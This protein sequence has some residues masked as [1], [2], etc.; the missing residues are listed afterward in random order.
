MAYQTA[1]KGYELK[2]MLTMISLV[3]ILFF[4]LAG[5]SDSMEKGDL[6]VYVEDGAIPIRLNGSSAVADSDSVRI[7]G[8]TIMITGDETY[9]ISGTLDDGMI[10]VNAK[11]S[12]TPHIVLSGACINSETSAAL[13]IL[14]ADKVVVTLAEGTQNILSNGG[15]F[16]AIDDSKID[17]AIFS[18]QD[19]T[20]NGSGS[21]NVTSPVGH[22][23]VCKKDLV[24]TGGVYTV[25][26]ASHGM[27]V[28]DSGISMKGIKA[29][30][31]ILIS[32]GDISIDS[33]DDAVHSDASVTINGG[34]LE[35]ASGDDAVHAEDTLIVTAGTICVLESYEG[36]EAKNIVV[37]GGDITI[38]AEDDGLNAAASNDASGTKSGKDGRAGQGEGSFDGESIEISGG[39]ISVT[40][41]GDGLDSNG[42]IAVLGG[43]L[44]ITNPTTDDTSVLDADSDAVISGGTFISTGSTRMMAQSFS[45]SSTQGVIACTTGTQSAGSVVTVEDRNGNMLVSYEAEYPYVLVIIS[46][47]ELVKGEAYILTAGSS[48]G[49]VTAE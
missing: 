7:S 13:Y 16:E 1:F 35:I 22:G 39:N 37:T 47:P 4:G 19:L 26:A 34:S 49:N 29:A 31:N 28:I 27:E 20:F 10:I 17:G 8:T 38:T 44:Y 24:F 3:F 21:L 18:K 48:S 32:G 41:S 6:G 40:A 12:A 11:A 15:S 25:T 9:L 5:Y 45:M 33:A 43:S 46:S 42:S 36:L 30:G 2:Y 23:V 14:N